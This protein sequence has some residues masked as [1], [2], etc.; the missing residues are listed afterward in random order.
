[1]LLLSC[2]YL[3][4]SPQVQVYIPAL[5]KPKIQKV[6]LMNKLQQL[7]QK[8]AEAKKLTKVS[9]SASTVAELTSALSAKPQQVVIKTPT[10]RV[11]TDMLIKDIKAKVNRRAVIVVNPANTTITLPKQYDSKQLAT[12]LG[13][14]SV[15]LAF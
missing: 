6:N 8:V 11:L 3:D 12:V 5:L 2:S 13:K 1:M 10:Q 9:E 7:K 15:A 14:Y 4:Y